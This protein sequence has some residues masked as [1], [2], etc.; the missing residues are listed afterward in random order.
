MAMERLSRYLAAVIVVVT[1]F[2]VA[3][4]GGGKPSPTFK[5]TPSTQNPQHALKG[6]EDCLSC[7][8][9]G[10]GTIQPADHASYTNA[11]CTYCH[12]VK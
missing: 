9:T 3:S 8:K 1:L 7:H 10:P 4:C 12:T 2:T 5:V 11:Y 6:F